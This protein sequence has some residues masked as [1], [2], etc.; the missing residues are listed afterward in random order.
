MTR[1]C[2]FYFDLFYLLDKA[3][4]EKAGSFKRV[5]LYPVLVT[6]VGFN[7]NKNKLS[8]N[9]EKAIILIIRRRKIVTIIE[10]LTVSILRCN[11]E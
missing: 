9:N 7:K 5:Q 3:F 8:N 2:N 11:R 10:M 1:V 4:F 6:S